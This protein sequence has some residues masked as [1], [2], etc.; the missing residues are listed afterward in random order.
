MWCPNGQSKGIIYRLEPDG[1]G[2]FNRIY[3]S[4]LSVL[5]EDYLPGANASY[6]LGGYN[7]FY[8]YIDPL[9]SD[10][11]HLVGFEASIAGGGHPT[12]NG[13]YKGWF[14]LP[15]RNSAG[16]Y[17]IEEI[18]GPIGVNDTALVANRCYA[19]S[20]F[21]N[22]NALYYGGFDPNSN[23]STNM[24]WIFKNDLQVT[25]VGDFPEYENNY[26]IYPK[27]NDRSI[28]Y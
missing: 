7:E 23:S 8:R 25:S 4:K 22:D 10:T 18:N 14:Y 28:F 12:W 19:V 16:E 13:Y 5:V 1:T 17:S 24:A 9:T 11:V 26:A 20:P 6:V 27:P 3:E 2:D 15:K 21:L